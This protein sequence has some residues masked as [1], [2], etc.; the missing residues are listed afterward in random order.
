[1]IIL[2]LDETLVYATETP[3]DR[4]PDFAAFTYSIYK[5]PFLD[6]FI[7]H[8]ISRYKVA[9]W[10]SSGDKYAEVVIKNIFPDPSLLVFVWDWRRCTNAFDPEYM[11]R[12]NIKDLKKV[13]RLGYNKERVIMID[14]S[15]EK[16]TRQY[17]NFVRVTPWNGD[18]D[19]CELLLLPRYLEI[20]D[21]EQ[22]I[23]T[24]EKRGWKKFVSR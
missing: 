19:D 5:R 21:G 16:T 3:L 12:R 2:D 9:V 15:P 1:L 18:P 24:I 7:S 20:L 10:T 13:F 4:V 6:S 8:L 11:F 23:R 17:G 14:D 22:N